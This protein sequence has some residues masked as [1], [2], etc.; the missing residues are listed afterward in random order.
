[1]GQPLQRQRWASANETAWAPL[2][3]P[4]TPKHPPLT[5]TQ[6]TP[7][8]LYCAVLQGRFAS[9]LSTGDELVLT[10]MVFAGLFTDMG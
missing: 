8:F 5:H 1:V 9:E 10:E 6:L 4:P 2:P 3:A 7:A